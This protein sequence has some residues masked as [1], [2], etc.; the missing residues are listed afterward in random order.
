MLLRNQFATVWNFT[1]TLAVINGA[2]HMLAPPMG[3]PNIRLMMGVSIAEV[4]TITEN[5]SALNIYDG[6][7]AS[8]IIA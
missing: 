2:A 4:G 6:K 3:G 7:P 8:G 5:V 1:V